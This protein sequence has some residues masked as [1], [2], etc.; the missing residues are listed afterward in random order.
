MNVLVINLYLADFVIN[1]IMENGKSG[2]LKN[3]PNY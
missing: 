1:V 3:C 2:D